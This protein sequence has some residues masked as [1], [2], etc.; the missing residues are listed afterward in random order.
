MTKATL[1]TKIKNLEAQL[2]QSV[3]VTHATHGALSVL[4]ELLLEEFPPV[5]PPA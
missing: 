2:T 5:P 4:Q 3:A 1:E